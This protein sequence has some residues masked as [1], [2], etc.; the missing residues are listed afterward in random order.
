MSC[1]NMLSVEKLSVFCCNMRSVVNKFP[2]LFSHLALLKNKFTIIVLTESWLNA[3]KDKALELPGYKSK[4]LY[5]SRK[6]GGIKV[7]YLEQLNMT[8]EEDLTEC[9]PHCESI[10]L[11]TNVRGIGKLNLVC[12]YRPPLGNFPLFKDFLEGLATYAGSH[13]T[14]ITGDFNLNTSAEP[15]SNETT[16][17]QELL[18][19]FGYRNCI[20]K[21]TYVR[22]NSSTDTSCLDHL[23]FNFG[24]LASSG[25]IKPNI[26]DHYAICASFE[27]NI[28]IAP[29]AIK[30]RDMSED[31]FQKLREN[32]QEEFSQYVAFNGCLNTDLR[33]LLTFLT[34]LQ[35]KYFPIKSKTLTQK[36]LNFP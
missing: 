24:H 26:S 2:L 34:K 15:L 20:D 21:K 22:P 27:T 3:G 5:R 32:M 9:T 36:R 28:I 33:N 8:V 13:R 16:E 14:I 17:Y 12:I 11:R 30:L 18:T 1:D 7:Y 23:W 29:M 6:G 35:D 10:F 31:D 4:S 19:C 25:V